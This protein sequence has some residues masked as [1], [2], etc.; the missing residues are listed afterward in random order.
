MAL[1]KFS[2]WGPCWLVAAAFVVSGCSNKSLQEHVPSFTSVFPYESR[3]VGKYSV[4][5]H[6]KAPLQWVVQAWVNTDAATLYA[7]S[8]NL[9][10]IAENVTWNKEGVSSVSAQICQEMSEQFLLL[11]CM[12]KRS[13]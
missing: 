2:L 12:S 4:D 5:N 8:M 13:C 10:G 6:T 11:G 7:K 9:D 1:N 3:D